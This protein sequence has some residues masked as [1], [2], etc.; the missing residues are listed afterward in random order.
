MC[1]TNTFH[2]NSTNYFKQVM[3]ETKLGREHKQHKAAAYRHSSISASQDTVV[4]LF[5]RTRSEACKSFKT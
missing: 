1:T 2:S 4:T 3:A 5:L